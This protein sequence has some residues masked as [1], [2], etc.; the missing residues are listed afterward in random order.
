VPGNDAAVPGRLREELVVPEADPSAQQLLGGADES[1]IP[2]KVM[3]AGLNPPRSQRV[4]QDRI[5]IG[6][7]VRMILVEQ[8]VSRVT[9]VCQPRQF[10]SK[11]IHLPVVQKTDT[12]H[13]PVFSKVGHLL[14]GE[15][16]SFRFPAGEQVPGRPVH[17]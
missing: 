10:F 2:K 15:P 3:E 11:L 17:F 8:R 12:A 1:W 9:R 4:E 14:I 6:G 5:R 16:K 7:F 13:V